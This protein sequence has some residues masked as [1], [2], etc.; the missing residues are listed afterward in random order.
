[1]SIARAAVITVGSAAGLVLAT[2]MVV[3]AQGTTTTT[4]SSG[5]N[6]GLVLIIGV[7]FGVACGLIANGKGR[8]PVLWGILG[9]LFGFIPLIIILVLKRKPPAY[10]SGGMGGPP[11]VPPPPP[12]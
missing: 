12:V 2:P 3:Q 5:A 4:T 8:S 1:M 11:M 10:S 9:F 7:V 6:W